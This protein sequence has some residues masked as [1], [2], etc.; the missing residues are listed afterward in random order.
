MSRSAKKRPFASYNSTKSEKE[1]KQEIHRRERRAVRQM[2]HTDHTRDLLPV[3]R[4]FGDSRDFGK[5]GKFYLPGLLS[6]GH[7]NVYAWLVDR[8]RK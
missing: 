6:K 8:L 4:D 1:D 3:S 2:L 7:D 5:D